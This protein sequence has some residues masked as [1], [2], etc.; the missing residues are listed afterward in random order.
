MEHVWSYNLS[1]LCRFAAFFLFFFF[2]LNCSHINQRHVEKQRCVLNKHIHFNCIH[3]ELFVSTFSPVRPDFFIYF[4]KTIFS[5]Q[6]LYYFIE[7][8]FFCCFFLNSPSILPV[9]SSVVRREEKL[10]KKHH[11]MVF[12]FS[13]W[14]KRQIMGKIPLWQ[15]DYSYPGLKRP[16][17]FELFCLSYLNTTFWVFFSFS[18]LV[19]CVYSRVQ[20]F[21]VVFWPCEILLS[22]INHIL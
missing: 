12:C 6:N 11:L 22:N 10:I 13:H 20:S 7:F 2:L 14:E 15:V 17:I 19:Y 16:G 18:S 5:L 4:Y 3:A 8:F 1:C 21:L 9:W